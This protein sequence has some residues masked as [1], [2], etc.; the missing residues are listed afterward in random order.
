MRPI[1]PVV[2]AQLGSLQFVPAILVEIAFNPGTD[3]F[4]Y[5]SWTRPLVNGGNTFSPRGMELS[6]PIS[7]GASAIV[8]HTSIKLDDVNR[9]VYFKLRDI[10][11]TLDQSV[12]IYVTVLKVED[13]SILGTSILWKGFMSGWGY[14]SG[15]TSIRL[16]SIMDRW[17]NIT[18]SKYSGSCR[19]KIF[20]GS[21]CMYTGPSTSCDRN[22]GT[23]VGYG[24]SSNFGGFRFIPKIQNRIR[25]ANDQKDDK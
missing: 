10:D 11:T 19:W 12:T 16:V 17:T 4:F 3:A 23:C 5:T 20:K 22:Y 2:I 14:S 18:T 21:E 25:H 7:Y 15:T 13:F 8:D 24:N 6:Q 9:D 1:D